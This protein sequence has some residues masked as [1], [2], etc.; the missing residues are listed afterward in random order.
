MPQSSIT[1]ASRYHC[2]DA[3]LQLSST[4]RRCLLDGFSRYGLILRTESAE[5]FRG[6]IQLFLLEQEVD[7][8]P[9]SRFTDHISLAAYH[10]THEAVRQLQRLVGHAC[11]QKAFLK[12]E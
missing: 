10:C 12:A 2:I 5:C 1:S 9:P 8:A 7:E 6:V 11:R 4:N 3:D